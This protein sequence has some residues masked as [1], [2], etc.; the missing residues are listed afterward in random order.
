MSENPTQTVRTYLAILRAIRNGEV[1]PI[2]SANVRLAQITERLDAGVTDPIEELKLTQE[3]LSIMQL[4][5]MF[6]VEQQFVE[7]ALQYSEAN[8][9]TYNAWRE[10]GVEANILASAGL[11]PKGTQLMLALPAPKKERK[12]RAKSEDGRGG[13]RTIVW[14]SDKAW[15]YFE[16]ALADGPI[17]TDED[18]SCYQKLLRTFEGAPEGVM[19]DKNL[20]NYII[21]FRDLGKIVCKYGPGRGVSG[22][23]TNRLLLEISL[24]PAATEPVPATSPQTK[25]QGRSHAA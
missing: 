4:V 11:Q 20:S 17:H 3:R 2:R 8:G 21:R 18:G 13:A 5:E 1:K 24:P 10:M 25:K 12:S 7:V 9:I 16:R 14:K 22:N 19:S 15:P 6:A 23:F